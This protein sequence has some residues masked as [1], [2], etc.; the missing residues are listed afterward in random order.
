[1]VVFAL[2]EALPVFSCV[3]LGHHLLQFGRVT[4]G[5][6]EEEEEEGEEEEERKENEKEKKGKEKKKKGRKNIF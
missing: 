6:K 1:M 3:K 4:G 5:E 2:E